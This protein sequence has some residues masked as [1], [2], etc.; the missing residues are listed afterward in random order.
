M[1]P[2]HGRD[3]PAA[4]LAGPLLDRGQGVEDVSERLHAGALAQIAASM[5]RAS[6]S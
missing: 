6:R 5:F 4:D 2:A 1:T 3:L